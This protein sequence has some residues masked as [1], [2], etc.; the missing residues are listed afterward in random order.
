MSL[1]LD[2]CSLAM[3][4]DSIPEQQKPTPKR[5]TNDPY[6]EFGHAEER[7]AAPWLDTKFRGICIMKA[8]PR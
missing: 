1:F 4:P 5:V 3:L 7:M 6:P 8:L 2:A